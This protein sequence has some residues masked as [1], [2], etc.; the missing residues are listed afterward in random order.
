VRNA[1]KALE[2]R[3]FLG[4]KDRDIIPEVCAAG[5]WPADGLMIGRKMPHQTGQ[6]REG[7]GGSRVY[8]QNPNHNG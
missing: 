8:G 5:G 7:T 1:G 6:L 4:V 3:R 2:E